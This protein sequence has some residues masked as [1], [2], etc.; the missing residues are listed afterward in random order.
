[1]ERK[2]GKS[3]PEKGRCEEGSMV[4][5]GAAQ[6]GRGSAG[7]NVTISQK[8]T[9]ESQIRAV[10]FQRN[11]PPHWLSRSETPERRQNRDI[12]L[13]SRRKPAFFFF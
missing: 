10:S 8:W 5:A 3:K 4:A 13:L 11:S 2:G 1:M 12:I 7:N 6:E 9:G